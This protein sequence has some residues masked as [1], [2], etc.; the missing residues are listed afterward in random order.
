MQLY[1]I[2]GLLFSPLAAA[3]AFLI[4][5]SEYSRHYVHKRPAIMMS[6]RTALMAFVFFMAL[7]LIAGY[8]IQHYGL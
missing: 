8:V 2:I 6:L 3:A 7:A 5:Y 1:L 4:S